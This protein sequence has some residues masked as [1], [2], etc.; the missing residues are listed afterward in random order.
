MTVRAHTHYHVSDYPSTCVIALIAIIFLADVS[1]G[2]AQMSILRNLPGN[3]CESG[4]EHVEG[5]GNFRIEILGPAPSSLSL[6][7]LYLLDSHGQIPSKTHNPEYE[8]IKQSQIDW[9]K[10]SAQGSRSLRES[11]HSVNCVHLSLVFQ[12]IPLPEFAD[13]RLQIHNGHREEPSE[14]PRVNSHFYDAMV[15]EGISAFSCGHD[16]V[17]DF[18]ALLPQQTLQDGYD[19]SQ[20]GP[21]LCYA[22]G[23][24]FGGYC[25]Y[26][27]SRF[28]RRMRVWELDTSTGSLTSWK[29]IEY[30]MDRADQ[31]VLIEN[32]I[33][34]DAHGKE[35]QSRNDV[36]ECMDM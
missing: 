30:G 8:P 26:G 5:V 29:R 6:S 15:E 21:W 13:S 24:G 14:G 32:G 34:V 33:V 16:H 9:F 22:G 1:S 35:Y 36:S 2:S 7:T 4:P 20:P 12:H 11:D 23:S 17:N 19:P 25:S 28:H 31:I 10:R 18:C 27:T 3:L